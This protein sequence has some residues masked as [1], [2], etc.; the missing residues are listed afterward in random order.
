MKSR[1][2]LYDATHPPKQKGD[3]SLLKSIHTIII[4]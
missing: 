3:A 2:K 1:A 4:I